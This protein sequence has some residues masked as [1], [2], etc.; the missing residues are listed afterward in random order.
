M[1]TAI[2]RRERERAQK[3]R[4]EMKLV[5]QQEREEERRKKKLVAQQE[6]QKKLGGY[7][8]SA[9]SM[10]LMYGSQANGARAAP[11]LSSQGDSAYGPP[12]Q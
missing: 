8:Q 4:Q 12:A 10:Q 2:S 3:Q 9:A 5:R 11:G 7:S 1:L 6:R